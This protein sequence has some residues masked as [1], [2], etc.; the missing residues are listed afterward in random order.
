V[1]LGQTTEWFVTLKVHN[2]KIGLW[3]APYWLLFCETRKLGRCSKD[4]LY[5]RLHSTQVI[6]LKAGQFHKPT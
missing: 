5:T 1:A 6:P 4:D 2:S 3:F